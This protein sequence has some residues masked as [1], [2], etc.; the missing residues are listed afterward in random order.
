[1]TIG[2]MVYATRPFG[3]NGK[4]LDPRQVVNLGG[5]RNDEKLMGMGYFAPVQKPGKGKKVE[6]WQCGV[7]GE[8]FLTESDRFIHG[9]NR[10]GGK[11]EKDEPVKLE[12]SVPAAN[13]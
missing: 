9:N 8:N 12:A 5:C 11:F 4:Q 10:H 2:E 13:N 7:C 1:M 6:L 3:Y